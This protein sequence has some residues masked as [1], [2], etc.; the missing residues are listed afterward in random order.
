MIHFIL[1]FFLCPATASNIWNFLYLTSFFCNSEVEREL[2]LLF[3]K[4]GSWRSGIGNQSKKVRE[5]TKF[6]MLVEDIRDGVLV[7]ILLDTRT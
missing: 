2:G 6:Q 1:L 3:P 7:C 5:G 4:G